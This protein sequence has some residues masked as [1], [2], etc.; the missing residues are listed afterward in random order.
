MTFVTWKNGNI[1]LTEDEEASPNKF[2]NLLDL[3]PEPHVEIGIL[4]GTA[5]FLVLYAFGRYDYALF[6][7]GII[8]GGVFVDL[9]IHD[10][11]H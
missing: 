8:L 10:Y 3:I 5:I 4:V 2:N 11:K 7:L 6:V 1:V 9:Y